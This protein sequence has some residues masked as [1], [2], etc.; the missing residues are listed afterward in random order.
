[1]C[2]LLAGKIQVFTCTT[3]QHNILEKKL[4]PEIIY[5]QMKKAI[6]ENELTYHDLKAFT[7]E[8]RHK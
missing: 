8:N 2:V 4:F 7:Q 6:D 5:F 3:G 1:M